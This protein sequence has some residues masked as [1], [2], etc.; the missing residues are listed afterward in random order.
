MSSESTV[1]SLSSPNFACVKSSVSMAIAPFEAAHAHGKIHFQS[2]TRR[3]PSTLVVIQP[4]CFSHSSR[5]VVAFIPTTPLLQPLLWVICPFISLFS[6]F[7]LPS[8]CPSLHPPADS[9]VLTRA[10]STRASLLIRLRSKL[11]EIPNTHTH[12][13]WQTGEAPEVWS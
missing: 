11:E 3:I 6:H 12:T 8:V 7:F 10:R 1:A 5:A 9:T 2:H 4:R 13:H